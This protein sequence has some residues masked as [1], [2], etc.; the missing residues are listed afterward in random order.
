MAGAAAVPPLPDLAGHPGRGLGSRRRRGAVASPSPP[1]TGST[2]GAAAARSRVRP[3]PRR[4]RRGPVHRR[5]RQPAGAARGPLAGRVR[6]SR[7]TARRPSRRPERRA[8]RAAGHPGRLSSRRRRRPALSVARPGRSPERHLPGAGRGLRRCR[9][10]RRRCGSCSG[11]F[12]RRLGPPRGDHRSPASSASGRSRRTSAAVSV[13]RRRRRAAR[14]PSRPGGA[15]PPAPVVGGAGLRTPPA[16]R[17]R[18]GLLGQVD[19]VVAAPLS[20]SLSLS[21]SGIGGQPSPGRPMRD[22]GDCDHPANRGVAACGRPH[23]PRRPRSGPALPRPAPAALRQ[24]V[25]RRPGGPPERSRRTWNLSSCTRAGTARRRPAAD[26]DRSAGGAESNGGGRRRRPERSGQTSARD[27]PRSAVARIHPHVAHPSHPASRARARAAPAAVSGQAAIPDVSQR[28]E[29]MLLVGRAAAPSAGRGRQQRLRCHDPSRR[30]GRAR[31]P[32]PAAVLSAAR[33]SSSRCGQSSGQGG[34]PPQWP[35]G[36]FGPH[37]PP[38]R[39]RRSWPA[40]TT[41]RS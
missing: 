34:G 9:R 28:D 25:R 7:R 17:G 18:R 26:A 39:R 24:P 5:R 20:S 30:T 3:M 29:Q 27:E 15:S 1:S 37:W 4:P 38:D 10:R 22:G 11:G 40:S 6:P 33:G 23:R 21:D 13:V 16:G 12:D 19:G 8:P 2:G 31:S 32:R 35:S 36:S 14:P 41:R